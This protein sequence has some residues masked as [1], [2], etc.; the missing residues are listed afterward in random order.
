MKKLLVHLESSLACGIWDDFV[1]YA[2]DEFDNNLFVAIDNQY[3]EMYYEYGYNTD[4]E[5]DEESEQMD[6]FISTMTYD[7]TEWDDK[8]EEEYGD[9]L[10]IIYDAR[11]NEDSS[12]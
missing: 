1:A 4:Y 8:I 3:I 6:E 11:D 9:N 12:N 5:S 10:P 2:E 7:I